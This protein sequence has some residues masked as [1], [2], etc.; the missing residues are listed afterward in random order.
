M[1]EIID[2]LKGAGLNEAAARVEKTKVAVSKS[3][4]DIGAHTNP[5]V[6]SRVSVSSEF[7]QYPTNIQAAILYHET[8]HQEQRANEPLLTSVIKNIIAP[9]KYFA[10]KELE[11]YQKQ[12]AALEKLGITGKTE[13]ERQLIK[14]IDKNI[15]QYKKWTK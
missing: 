4:S 7:S 15:E 1:G 9:G 14:T 11:A 8:V 12:K 13:L 2:L 6:P 3:L 5:I 10:Q